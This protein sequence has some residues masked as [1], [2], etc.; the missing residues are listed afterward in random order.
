LD[1]VSTKYLS[2]L[3][4][5]NIKA[6][7]I[8]FLIAVVH[9]PF[10]M[11]FREAGYAAKP[12][13]TPPQIFR[14]LTKMDASV[15]LSNGLITSDI[16]IIDIR[17]DATEMDLKVEILSMLKPAKGPKKMPTLLLY[18]ET[19]LQIFE[20]VGIYDICH[21]WKLTYADHVLG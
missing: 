21:I 11:R 14:G 10:T 6:A 1:L 13:R 16:D 18:N 5:F 7:E 3:V 20:K 4:N 8:L 9:P 17:S 12:R 2:V 15:K 19:G